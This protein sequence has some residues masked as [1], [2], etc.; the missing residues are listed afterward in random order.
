MSVFHV[1]HQFQQYESYCV[2][3]NIDEVR[4]AVYHREDGGSKILCNVDHYLST[5]ASTHETKDRHLQS[6]KSSI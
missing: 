6:R 2:L 3:E 4:F 1:V 5:C